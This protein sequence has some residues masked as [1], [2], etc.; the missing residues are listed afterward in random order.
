MAQVSVSS[1][2]ISGACR[3]VEEGA[4]R[5]MIG[6][7]RVAEG[8]ADALIPLCDQSVVVEIL[9]R[10]VAPILARASVEEFGEGFGETIRERLYHD[11]VV[12]VVILLEARGELVGFDAA[13]HGERADVVGHAGLVRRYKI[14]ERAV[15]LAVWVH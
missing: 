14:S 7:G 11:R 9:F 4:L 15:G 2:P 5:E 12:V 1:M 6:A 10:A 8:R 3:D 13:G